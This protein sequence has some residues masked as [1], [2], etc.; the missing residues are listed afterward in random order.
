MKVFPS[1]RFRGAFTNAAEYTRY[2]FNGKELDEETGFYYYG[3]RYYN[4][5]TSI[6]LSVD[7]LA[8]K[9]PNMSPYIYT[10]NNP[11]NY[12][13]PDGRKITDPIDRLKS[14]ISD[15]ISNI[16]YA[17]KESYAET[18]EDPGFKYEPAGTV[19]EVAYSLGKQTEGLPYTT[20][21]G[22]EKMAVSIYKGVT[23]GKEPPASSSFHT[24]P[25]PIVK[26]ERREAGA[27]SDAD[28]Y[29]LRGSKEGTVS[30]V[31]A[32]GNTTYALI[33]TDAKAAKKFFNKNSDDVIT[34]KYN[35]VKNNTS[36]GQN[37]S[38]EAAVKSVLGDNSGIEFYKAQGTKDNPISTNFEK[39][40]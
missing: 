29:N 32:E 6:W 21:E 31:F 15:N 13:D 3:A 37:A 19:R 12:I 10:A 9:Y 11:V 14:Y 39:I 23:Q 8:D 40:E 38:T 27:H 26:G 1:G 22:K 33:I 5:Q 24:H 20:D 7:P 18:S 36:G 17:L 34:A 25:S 30:V 4:P 28:I 35:A 2:L 16:Q